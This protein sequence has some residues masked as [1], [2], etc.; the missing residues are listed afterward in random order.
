MRN[1]HRTGNGRGTEKVKGSRK[2]EEF[3]LRTEQREK[4]RALQS[5]HIALSPRRSSHRDLIKQA[6]CVFW[7]EDKKKGK[8]YR[9]RGKTKKKNIA[10]KEWGPG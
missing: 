5:D 9:E 8:R 10:C 1:I 6:T 4:G 2:M 7:G 3:W